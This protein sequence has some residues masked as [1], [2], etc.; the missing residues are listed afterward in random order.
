LILFK[1]VKPSYNLLDC[2]CFKRL[3]IYRSFLGRNTFLHIRK[4]FFYVT[5]SVNYAQQIYI[6]F[7]IVFLFKED[8]AHKN[9]VF[10]KPY[11]KLTPHC[12]HRS[13]HVKTEHSES[14]LLLRRHLEN[15]SCGPAVRMSCELL[16]ANKKFGQ[17]PLLTMYVMP[18]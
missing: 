11:T 5:I 18:V 12:N 2:T 9:N 13:G 8:A 17:L 15:W 14:L 4:H 3:S 7:L 6:L 10:F 16:L 1:F